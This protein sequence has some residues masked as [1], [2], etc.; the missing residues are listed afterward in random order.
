MLKG[1]GIGLYHNQ[2]RH[3]AYT[4]F[5][6]SVVG[7]IVSHSQLLASIAV[8]LAASAGVWE[9][10]AENV[11]G[12]PSRPSRLRSRTWWSQARRSPSNMASA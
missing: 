6:G 4:I 10:P 8:I 1:H 2:A 3:D 12:T 5:I 7:V 9:N 11:Y